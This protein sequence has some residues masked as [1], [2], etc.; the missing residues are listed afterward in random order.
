[1]SRLRNNIEID[2]KE[3]EIYFLK[4]T[5]LGLFDG[6]DKIPVL[7]GGDRTIIKDNPK[8]GKFYVLNMKKR[9]IEY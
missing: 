1:V 4:S 2:A 6:V 3:G 7:G 9:A 8:I 5:R